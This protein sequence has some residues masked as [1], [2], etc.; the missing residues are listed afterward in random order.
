MSVLSRDSERQR[1]ETSCWL[2]KS[3]HMCLKY[4]ARRFVRRKRIRNP[5]VSLENDQACKACDM[6][7]TGVMWKLKAYSMF[8]GK[9][10]L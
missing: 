3:V 1:I 7:A 6:N 2:Y 10:R 4:D 5:N 9:C 8:V